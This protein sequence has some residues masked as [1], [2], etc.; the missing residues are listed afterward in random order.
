MIININAWPGTG[1]LSVAQQLVN[2]LGGRLLDNHTVYDVAFSL[3]DFG[4][5]EFYETVRAVRNVAFARIV[6]LAADVPVTLTS[7]YADTPFGRDNWA[8][9]RRIADQRGSPLCIVVLDCSLSEN[10]RRLQTPERSRSR[11]LIDPAPLI[12]ARET[13][14][15]LEAGGDYLLRF[16]TT[17]LSAA[18]S[19]DRIAHWIG[20]RQLLRQSG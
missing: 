8:A 18:E 17:E 12:S 19:A 10:L 9:I 16:D 3:Y 15:L 11:K 5:P 1:K 2:R 7:A 20:E 13:H 6:A 4:T 14:T